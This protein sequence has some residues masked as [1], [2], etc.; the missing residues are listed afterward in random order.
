MDAISHEAVE[1]ALRRAD[2]AG[3]ATARALLRRAAGVLAPG[4]AEAAD[5]AEVLCRAAAVSEELR[6]ELARWIGAAAGA[7]SHGNTIVGGDHH[8][9]IVQAHTVGEIHWHTA[10]PPSMALPTPRQLIAA[11]RRLS[12]RTRE[13]AELDTM[14]QGGGQREGPLV[15]VVNGPAG[16][17]KTALAAHWLRSVAADFPDGQLFADLRGHAPEGPVGPPESLAMFLRAFGLTAIPPDPAERAALWRSVTAGRRLLVMLDNALSAAQVRPLLPG[18]GQSIVVITSRRRLTGLGLE[19]A[20]F[21]PLGVLDAEA[22]AEILAQRVGASRTAA[23]PAA[24]RRVVDRCGGL[25]LA[26]CV[27]AARMAARPGQPLAATAEALD[28]GAHRLAELRIGEEAAVRSALDASYRQLPPDAAAL[29]RLLG[30]LPFVEL[31]LPVVAAAT[32]RDEAAADR[33][34]EVLA[35]ASLLEEPAAGRHRFHDLI[36]LHARGLAE[37]HDPD[38]I[39][40]AAVRRALEWYLATATAAEAL[41]SP[42]HRV[43]DRDYE[44]LSPDAG[45]RFPDQRGALAW[46]AAEQHHL[47]TALRTA[48]ALGWNGL[49]WQ[50]ADAMWPLWLRLRPYDLWV[51]A[52][53]LGLAAAR[54][55]SSLPGELRMLTDGGAGLRNGGRPDEAVKSFGEAL[56][57]ART[58]GDRR[59]EAQALHGLGQSHYLAGRPDEAAGF[60]RRALRLRE[61]IGYA[62]GAALSRISLGDTMRSVGRPEEAA[63]ELR[64]ART[65]LLALPDPYE[66][67]RALALLGRALGEA[68]RTGPAERC[69]REAAEEFRTG[70][71]AH[72]EA[73]SL[74]MLGVVLQRA[75]RPDDARRA[76]ERS[77][78]LYEGAGAPDAA[79]L[80]ARLAPPAPGTESGTAPAPGSGP[81]RAPGAGTS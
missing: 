25:A 60:F 46:L 28:H 50:L 47:M 2:A 45:L 59:V 40:T 35:E 38:A 34:I 79:R 26:V 15:A 12:G 51:E 16:V 42:N 29:Y 32:G 27:A 76:F 57:L 7:G 5:P 4:S 8:A 67:S 14:W 55:D 37:V 1:G 23:E 58:V 52:H 43:L 17:G 81:G 75:G 6:A 21:H 48:A 44:E 53:R 9:G 22:S 65:E 80:A 61:E 68:G 56:E 64:R 63:E 36:R 33:L 62:R 66:A 24:V 69:L 72:W 11:P 41:V 74:E 10:A 73:Y 31:T 70:G 3:R 20:V 30:V 78:A 54:R 39:R 18:S 71:S 77:L 19:G 13:L 49:C